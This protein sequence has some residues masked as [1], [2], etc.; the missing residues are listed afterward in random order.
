[1]SPPAI[2]ATSPGWEVAVTVSW[3]M[4]STRS[5]VFPARQFG[6]RHKPCGM[7]GNKDQAQFAQSLSAQ[8]V[9]NMGILQYSEAPARMI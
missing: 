7:Q 5:G 4:N 6:M 2:T 3:Q 1:M 9:A 8:A